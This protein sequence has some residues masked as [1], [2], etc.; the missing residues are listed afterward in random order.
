[1]AGLPASFEAGALPPFSIM[2]SN[3]YGFPRWGHDRAKFGW[4]DGAEAVAHPEFDRA[5]ATPGFRAGI[6]RLF[7]DQF[8]L[9]P[10]DLD[11]EWASCLY[12]VSPAGDFLI[13]AVPGRPGV[14]VACG[15]SGHG[16][17]FGSIIGRI[18]M[19]RLEGRVDPGEGGWW[20]PQFSW[21]AALQARR[22]EVSATPI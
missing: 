17:K 12:D 16:F 18:V 8:N 21:S 10:A 9:D 1:V 4:H 22:R 3:A 2:G 14:F 7:G 13:D 6:E 11:V 19:D 15:S 5:A 20:L